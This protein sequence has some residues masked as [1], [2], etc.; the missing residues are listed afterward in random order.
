[1]ARDL[2][3]Y[4]QTNLFLSF[5]RQTGTR[6]TYCGPQGKS[7]L[8]VQRADS[9][10]DHCPGGGI[11]PKSFWLK[12]LSVPSLLIPLTVL[13]RCLVS[14]GPQILVGGSMDPGSTGAHR[15]L[16]HRK[17]GMRGELIKTPYSDSKPFRLPW[18]AS[19]STGRH[20]STR[21]PHRGSEVSS[22]RCPP[23][24]R[25]GGT[26]RTAAT[27][28]YRDRKTANRTD[29]QETKLNIQQAQAE[30]DRML[31]SWPRRRLQTTNGA[32]RTT[33]SLAKTWTKS[34]SLPMQNLHWKNF[35]SS[36]TI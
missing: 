6:P 27:Q 28:L 32:T 8:C 13:V 19:A 5:F 23:A 31:Y 11:F 33:F 9:T 1:M 15:P 17:N 18:V 2:R 12:S 16:T 22:Y 24:Q 7:E 30:A 3:K 34:R 21:E 35:A 20:Y 10:S 14:G 25:T 26:C 36:C 29:L 4:T